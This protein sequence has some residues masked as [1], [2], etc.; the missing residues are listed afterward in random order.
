MTSILLDCDPGHDDMMAIML[1]SIHPEINLLGI[2]TVAGN[3][4]GDKT[5]ENTR[6]IL[7]LIGETDL[8]LVRGADKPLFRDLVVAPNIHGSSGLDGAELPEPRIDGLPFHAADFIIEMVRDA[9]KPVTLVPTGP[10]TNIAMAL[11]KDPSITKNIERICFM[12]GAVYDSN[13][14]P[15]AEFNIYVDPEAAR[16]VLESGVPLTMVGLDVTNKAIINFRHIREMASWGG[17]ASSVVAPLMQFFAEANEK[18]FGIQGGPIHDAL[19]VAAVIDPKVVETLHLNVQVETCSDLTR[20]QTL[21]DLYGVTGREPNCDV[22]L[23]VD[24]DRFIK[25]MMD[26]LK[27]LDARLA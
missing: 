20:G 6:R 12:G 10:L 25:L 11:I 1:A 22:A 16:I 15:A 9:E 27:E 8:P 24:V 14:T 7:T 13:I 19:A 21:A 4:T 18:A 5:F 17:K 3:Q 23:K 2:T 26:S